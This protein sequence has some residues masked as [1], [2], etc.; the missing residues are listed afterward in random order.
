MDKTASFSYTNYTYEAVSGVVK[1]DYSVSVP[2]LENSTSHL[3]II[4]GKFNSGGKVYKT[5]TG[6]IVG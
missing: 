1:F 5:K 2:G 6:R 3:L 4:I